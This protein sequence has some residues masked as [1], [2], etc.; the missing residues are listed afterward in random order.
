MT[1]IGGNVTERD[2]NE[3]PVLQSR[4][5][6]DQAVGCPLH[7]VRRRER[8]PE[9]MRLPVG[10]HAGARCDQIKIK[11]ALPPTDRSFPPKGGLDLMQDIEQVSG[12]MRKAQ[13]RCRVHKFGTRSRRKGRGAIK[14]AQYNI[15]GAGQCQSFNRMIYRVFR[16]LI[17]ERH[18]PAERNQKIMI[19]Q[20]YGL[21]YYVG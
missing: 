20:R 1:P 2:K 16:G 19:R 12:G 7:L 11:G 21:S 3:G 15:C 9:G 17:V 10:Q 14:W 5:R 4:M 13:R 8:T 18:I 6:Q